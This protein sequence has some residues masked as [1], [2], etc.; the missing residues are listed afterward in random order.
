M[1]NGAW[2]ARHL[3]RIHSNLIEKYVREEAPSI[4]GTKAT[5]SP[6]PTVYSFTS[7][8]YGFH[9]ESSTI[10]NASNLP[11][12]CVSFSRNPPKTGP[13]IRL[14]PTVQ[15]ASRITATGPFACIKALPPVVRS[16]H[17]KEQSS[18]SITKGRRVLNARCGKRG[19]HNSCRYLDAT[20]CR[21]SSKPIERK[22]DVTRCESRSS[23][24][25][26]CLCVVSPCAC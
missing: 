21:D 22:D 24:R 20:I 1:Q 6:L 5:I 13:R 7:M 2:V 10:V 11:R 25:Q 15:R 18:R 14:P 4:L 23:Y 16:L 12:T 19:E 26:S 3:P 8:P 17:W 9:S